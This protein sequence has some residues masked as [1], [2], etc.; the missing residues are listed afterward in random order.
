MGFSSFQAAMHNN[1][2]RAPDLG[3]GAEVRGRRDEIYREEVGTGVNVYKGVVN[4]M[5][6]TSD[7]A[8]SRH[9]VGSAGEW[10]GSAE[11]GVSVCKRSGGSLQ[12]QARSTETSRQV[13]LTDVEKGSVENRRQQ[14]TGSERERRCMFG[15]GSARLSSARN[16]ATLHLPTPLR[17]AHV[18]AGDAAEFAKLEQ[19]LRR[20]LTVKLKDWS[21]EEMLEMVGS[22][23]DMRD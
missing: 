9:V 7:F 1:A 18:P 8:L 21:C 4:E 16:G 14:E 2:G 15:M 17:N 6:I 20:S 19:T 12:A 23:G 10:L 22:G 11:D 13:S 5:V 3:T